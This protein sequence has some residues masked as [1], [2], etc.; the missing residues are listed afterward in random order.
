M[1]LFRFPGVYR[2]QD[3]TALL[4]DA[5]KAAAIPQGSRVLDVGC[6]TGAL[7][8]V[9]AQ[10]GAARVTAVDL[11]LLAVLSG[12]INTGLRGLPV[13]VHRGDVIAHLTGNRYDVILANPPYVPS[14]QPTPPARGS[15]IAW[16]AGPDGR[17]L[18]DK[19]CASAPASLRKDGVFLVVHSTLCGVEQTLDQLRT[20][21]LK[22][23][24]VARRRIPFGPVL[25]SRIPYLESK[26]LISPGQRY[27]ELVVIRGDRANQAR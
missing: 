5:F 8:I 18:L 23:A 17:A 16:D 25:S 24:V 27:E 1:L 7:S 22:A 9:A 26:A 3:D 2:P 6:G 4:V 12:R 14:A 19:L 21:G 13:E 11:S 10:R 20:G 15:S